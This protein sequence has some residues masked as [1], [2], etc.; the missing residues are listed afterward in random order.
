MNKDIPK[1]I[2]IL[3]GGSAGWMAA[4]LI[5]KMW[6]KHNINIILVESKNIGTIGVGEGSTPYM[7]DFFKIL[8]IS[9]SQWMPACH[10]TYKCGISFPNWQ[11][12]KNS[13]YFHPF[14]SVLDIDS[15]QAFFQNCGFK[16]KGKKV[17]THPDD[18]FVSAELARQNKAPIA[19]QS[20]PFEPDYGYHFDAGLLAKFLKKYCLSKGL[21]HKIATIKTVGKDSAGNISSLVTNDNEELVADFF[22]DCTGFASVLISKN[23]G[24]EFESFSDN[25]FND[26]A[27][28]I[29]TAIEK[30]ATIASY[31]EST[32][33]KNGWAWKIPLTSRIGNGYVYSSKFCTDEEAEQEFRDHLGEQSQGVESRLIKLKVGKIKKHWHKNCLAV[34]LSQGFI[35][36]LE[37]TALML[38]Q[39][40]IMKFMETFEKEGSYELGQEQYNQEIDKYFDGVRDY[41]VAHYQLNN[42]TDTDYWCAN[43]NHS[44]VSKTFKDLINTWEQGG[45]FEACLTKHN[46]N[47]VYLRPSWYCMFAGMNRFPDK[48]VKPTKNKKITA[49]KTVKK[50]CQDAAQIFPDHQT[51]L[52]KLYLDN[53]SKVN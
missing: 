11:S 17:H 15:A 42:R 21:N 23:L 28:A 31:T 36:P 5:Q 46:D 25:L 2:I 19:S 4:S 29:P 35:E 14:F 16:R 32:A 38:V 1:N 26:S 53:W 47:I 12:E 45:D 30:E 20:L 37:A 10:A 49:H 40:T 8:G 39:I 9:E 7:R 48:L 34:G 3:G 22:V 18:F 13:G 33:L 51:Y 27:I 44:N 50:Y 43:R 24:V 41:I 52:K 6:D